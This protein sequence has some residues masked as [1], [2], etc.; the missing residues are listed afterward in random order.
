MDHIYIITGGKISK[1]MDNLFLSCFFGAINENTIKQHK[2]DCIVKMYGRGEKNGPYKYHENIEYLEIDALDIP[3]YK[4]SKDFVKCFK[5]INDK[6]KDKK[7]VLVHCHAGIS[8]SSTI[9]IMYLMVKY[10]ISMSKAYEYVKSR[11]YIINPNNG[12]CKELRRLDQFLNK[13]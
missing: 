9:V 8:R 3:E 2:I 6:I 1:I 11:R 4:I 13:I 12:F 10:K 5:F 7:N